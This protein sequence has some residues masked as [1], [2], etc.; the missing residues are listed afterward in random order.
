MASAY[1]DTQWS[2]LITGAKQE[3]RLLDAKNLTSSVEGLESSIAS[4]IDHTQLRLDATE[5]Q[6]RQLCSE[7]RKE[8]FAVSVSLHS[9]R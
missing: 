4:Y 7:A 9:P 6:I 5:D 8:K 2:E 1:S 3:I